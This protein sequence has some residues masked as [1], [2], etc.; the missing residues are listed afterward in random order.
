MAEPFL[1]V[2]LPWAD[3]EYSFSLGIDQWQEIARKLFERFTKLGVSQE[4]ALLA[5]TPP[6]I[7]R[8]ISGTRPV[9]GEMGDI[10]LQALIGG[11]MKPQQAV[12]LRKMYHDNRPF[13]ENLQLLQAIIL[14]QMF[15]P[16]EADTGK[17]AQAGETPSSP[18]ADSMKTAQ[19]SGSA[20][21]KS[22]K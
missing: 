16:P 1:P 3:G 20:R 6:E 2:V 7:Y 21:R 10:L 14:H 4:V 22:A 18:S 13:L 8:R 19:P 12:A 17:K 15:G 5:I 9:P 11:G